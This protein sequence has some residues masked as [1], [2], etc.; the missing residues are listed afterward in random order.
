MDFNGDGKVT[1]ATKP[2]T[3]PT[4]GNARVEVYDS[5]AAAEAAGKVLD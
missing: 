5:R 3:K 1:Y 2:G 4:D